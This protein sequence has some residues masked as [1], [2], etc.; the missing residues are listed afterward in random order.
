M[1]LLSALGLMTHGEHEETDKLIEDYGLR[2]SPRDK[3][4]IDGMPKALKA[5]LNKELRTLIKFYIHLAK[6]DADGG[7]E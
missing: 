1:S 6:F 3:H 2:V 4:G 5:Q 7:Q